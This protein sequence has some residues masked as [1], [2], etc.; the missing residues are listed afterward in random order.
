[1]N[2]HYTLFTCLYRY[3]KNVKHLYNNVLF[4]FEYRSGT[5]CKEKKPVVYFNNL[6]E[7][8]GQATLRT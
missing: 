6:R 4:Y 1:M 3:N 2:T 7:Y 5:D 8:R